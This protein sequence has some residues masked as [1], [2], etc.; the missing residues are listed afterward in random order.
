[1]GLPLGLALALPLPPPVALALGL[2][3]ALALPLGLLVPLVW[4]GPDGLCG[5]GVGLGLVEGFA[6]A[7]DRVG[8]AVPAFAEPDECCGDGDGHGPA[9]G[10]VVP[11]DAPPP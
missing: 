6:D 11:W 8:L 5:G 10:L 9:A 2:G 1:M 4:D 3:L 7:V